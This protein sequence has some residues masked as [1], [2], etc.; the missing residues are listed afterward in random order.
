MFALVITSI[1]FTSLSTLCFVFYSTVFVSFIVTL[2]T[3]AVRL[4]QGQYSVILAFQRMLSAYIICCIVFLC[5]L[6]HLFYTF[7]EYAFV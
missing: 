6:L 1:H 4:E 5:I 2:I 3:A 7:D